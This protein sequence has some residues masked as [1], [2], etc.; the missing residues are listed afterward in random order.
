MTRMKLETLECPEVAARFLKHVYPHV[1][2]EGLMLGSGAFDHLQVLG[3]GSS[4]HAG[5]T[6]RYGASGG[7][8]LLVSAAMPSITA[9]PVVRPSAADRSVVMAISQSGK[10][11]DLI[12]YVRQ[13][14]L[15]GARVCSLVNAPGSPLA[16]ES[17]RAIELQAGP[18]L[19]VA[20][21]KSTFA[22]GLACL[23]LLAG[24]QQAHSGV[25]ALDALLQSVPDKARESLDLNWSA[26]GELIV[27]ARSV[28]FVGRGAT[29]GIAKELAL[30]VSE[31]T[32][33]PAMAYSSAEFL[34]GPIG[35]VD[36][37]TPVIA[38]NSDPEQNDSFAT[39]IQ[40]SRDRQA[41]SLLAQTSGASDLPIVQGA[42]RFIDG[43]LMLL[44]AYLAIE[45]AA[46]GMGRNPDAPSG[47]N[48][49]TE[50][51]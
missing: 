36:D 37:K 19:A 41:P 18:E 30:K 32:G 23:G 31:T 21:T 15:H 7:T 6:L 1:H 51:V 27:D 43:L 24:L 14:R 10:S 4:S 26:L 45:A 5:T 42:D 22:A 28:F 39:C 2:D 40:R 3:R 47:L 8:S 44:P 13:S 11:P 9:R 17:H 38:L 50:T 46:T 25:N 20:A 29:L 12:N 35:A 34:H 16:Q 33:V 49:V 48:K